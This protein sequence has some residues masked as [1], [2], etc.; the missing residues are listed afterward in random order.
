M[1]TPLRSKGAPKQRV[2]RSMSYPAPVGGWNA[3]DALAAMKPNQAVDLVNWFPRTSYCEIRGGYS[4][5]ATGTTGN[6][7]TLAVWN[8]PTGTSKMFASTA[9]G[10]YDVSSAGVVGASVASR[11]NGKHQTLNFADGTNNYLMMFNGADKPLYYDGST[12]TAVDGTSSPALTGL[13]TTNIVSAFTFKGR[14]IFLEKNSLSFWY[15]PAGVAGGALMEFDLGGVAKKGGY[16]MAA[17]TWTID[18]GDGADDKAVFVTSEGEVL[19]Y[20]GT[21]PSSST[22]WALVGV[23]DLG[24]PLGRRCLTKFGGDLVIITQNGVFPLSAALQTATIDNRLAITNIIEDAF[25]E[26]ARSYGSNFGWE[27]TLYSAQGALVVN[28]PIAEDGRHEQ[29]VMNTITKAW[30]KF[31]SWN[32]ETFAVFNGELYYAISTTVQKAWTGTI[33]GANNI[34][35]V[36]KTAFSYFGDM[37]SQKRYNMFRPVL[38]VNGTLSFLTDIDVDFRDTDI[39]G[40]AT[41]SVVAGG[42]WDVAMWDQG[43]WAAGMEIIKEWT[44]PDEDL[45]Y[46]ASGKIK[47]ETNS[48]TVQWLAQDWIYEVGNAL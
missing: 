21:N 42:Q 17:A 28:V 46:C 40:T 24:K 35:A 34:V 16:L 33:D 20:Q 14:L 8:G 22:A 18:A 38:A 37:G 29:Y 27:A 41:Y 3:R 23:Y 6:V 11:T 31:N 19:V 9:S 15:L 43:Y 26:A 4:S 7:K 5:H 36:G 13:T 44:S 1:R 47:V 39:T 12:W 32:A 30:C 10:V 48:L 2:S 45:G 25:A